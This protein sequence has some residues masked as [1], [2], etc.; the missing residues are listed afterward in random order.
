MQHLL[1][2]FIIL[3]VGA[4]LTTPTAWGTDLKSY[5]WKN[6][7]LLVF[8]P[9]ES[10]PDFAAFDRSLTMQDPE[11]KDRDLIVFRVFEKD[12]SR[13]EKQPLAPE[14]AD[15]LRRRFKAAPGRF[16]VILIGKDGG[17]KMVREHRAALAEIFDLIDSMPM[18]QQEMREKGE[19][20]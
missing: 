18:R 3:A 16:T 4:V 12:P 19:N 7:L 10:N 9:A 20:R 15:K 2:P 17:V 6:R 11:V 8:S 5:R 1:K 13:L 14:D